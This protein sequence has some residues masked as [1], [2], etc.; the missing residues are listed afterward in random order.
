[1]KAFLK[2]L[3]RE[4]KKKLIK[5]LQF[6]IHDST[7]YLRSNVLQFECGLA[8]LCGGRLRG[9]S[10]LRDIKLLRSDNWLSLALIV[11]V[12]SVVEGTPLLMVQSEFG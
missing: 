1:V 8:G 6:S 5:I 4:I 2:P 10:I 7:L 3:L 11:E 9:P 12:V